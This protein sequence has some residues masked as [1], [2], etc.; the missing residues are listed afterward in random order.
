MKL[1]CDEALNLHGKKVRIKYVGW[2]DKKNHIKDDYY[3]FY[4]EAEVYHIEKQ[5][6][7]KIVQTF[8]CN[9]WYGAIE[10]AKTILGELNHA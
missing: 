5:A 2:F 10:M 6:T 8:G 1:R 9:S 7:G 4:D 3:L